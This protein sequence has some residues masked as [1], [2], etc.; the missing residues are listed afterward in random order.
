MAE[1][2]RLRL[3]IGESKTDNTSPHLM[4]FPVWWH[5]GE[6]WAKRLKLLKTWQGN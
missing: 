6:P 2:Y 1:E 5:K 3:R 4:I